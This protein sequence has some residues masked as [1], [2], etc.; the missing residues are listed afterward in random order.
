M[1]PLGDD[2]LLYIFDKIPCYIEDKPLFAQVSK[3]FMKVACV[4]L[5]RLRS[6][7]PDMLFDILPSSP[8]MRRF[9]CSKPLSNTHLKLLAHSCP[10]LE[11]LGIGSA[12]DHD[13]SSEPGEFDS[14]FD[15][16]GLRAV[17]NSCSHLSEVSLSRRLH[18]GDAGIVSLV[19]SSKNLIKLN[20]E[21]C[22]R[23]TDESLK[24][25]GESGIHNLNLEECCLITDLGLEYLAVGDLKKC[26]QHLNLSKCDRISDN[27]VIHLK[28]MV[29][30]THLNLSKC[31]VHV[32]DAGI[33]A[34]LSQ[35]TNIEILDL[36]WLINVADIS[37][38]AIGSKCLKLKEINL[39]GCEAISA[40][41]LRAFS[42]HQ[43]LKRLTLF[44]C[45]NFSWEDVESVALTCVGLKYLGLMKSIK[46]PMPEPS[47]DYLQIGRWYCGIDWDEDS[48]YLFW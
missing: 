5:H 30:L 21:G 10:K 38:L 2:E 43:T 34:L 23:V 14:D 9:S 37:L 8:N 11:L 6:C 22:I 16:D 33:A 44:S 20:L 24:A 31:G 46:T 26:L 40:E 29:G 7:F 18:V 27:G 15:D 13:P 41:G 12:Q 19:T 47:F 3:Q 4:R 42:G 39:N 17:G 32:T 35:L 28:Q 1:E 25:I 36:S 45:Y 48:D